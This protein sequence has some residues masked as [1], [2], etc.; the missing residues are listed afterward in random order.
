MDTD[1]EKFYGGI[2]YN[3]FGEKLIKCEICGEPTTMLGT[4][5][6]DR[7]HELKIRIERDPELTKKILAAIS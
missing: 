1:V 4:K 3:K 6:C 5:H 7:C 2:P